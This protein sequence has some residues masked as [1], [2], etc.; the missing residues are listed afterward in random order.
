MSQAPLVAEK[1][2]ASPAKEAPPVN[3]TSDKKMFAIG[4]D[5]DDDF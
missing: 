1:K 5:S 4:D 2:A 3:Q